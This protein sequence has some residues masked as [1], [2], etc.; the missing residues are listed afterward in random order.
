MMSAGLLRRSSFSNGRCLSLVAMTD[1][2]L[3]PFKG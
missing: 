3:S 1:T 2:L